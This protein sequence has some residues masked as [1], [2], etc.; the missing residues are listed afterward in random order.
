MGAREEASPTARLCSLGASPNLLF[1]PRPD[2]TLRCGAGCAPSEG[3]P[4]SGSLPADFPPPN[5]LRPALGRHPDRDRD[6]DP[7]ASAA[8][9][10]ARSH[11]DPAPAP[12]RRGRRAAPG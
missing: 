6:P 10:A 2:G 7:A 8:A 1:P 9:A 12:P 4:S 3:V 11:P 5:S